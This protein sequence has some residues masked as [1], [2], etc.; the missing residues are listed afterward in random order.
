MSRRLQRLGVLTR[1]GL[2]HWDRATVWGML[3]NP[4]YR[5]QAAYGKTCVGKRRPR[6]RPRKGQPD[7]SKQAHSTYAQAVEK[8]VSIAVPALVD[9]ESFAAVQERLEENRKRQRQRQ[10]GAS[11]LLQGLAVCGSCGYAIIG[12]R[13][14]GSRRNPAVYYRCLGTDGSRFGGVAVCHDPMSRAE[15]LEEAVWKDVV[16]LLSDPERLRQEFERRQQQS[17]TGDTREEKR[18]EATRTKVKQGLSRLIDA[19]AEGLL[20]PAEFEPRVRGMK[21]R[22]GQVEKELGRLREQ[23]QQ[24]EQWREMYRC[25]KEFAERMKGQL[26]DA[27][28]GKRREILRSVVKRVEVEKTNLRIIYKVPTRPFVDGPHKGLLQDCC[29]RRVTPSG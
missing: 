28:W 2:T 20:E 23:A 3:T 24:E 21:E 8:Q 6:L 9:A 11:H 29:R 25:A 10:G 14:S 16:D 18:L 26:A 13:T 22:M 17:A 27:D 19:Y 4:A 7:V 1:T 5:G 12:R 15:D